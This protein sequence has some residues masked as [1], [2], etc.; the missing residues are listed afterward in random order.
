MHR[1]LIAPLAGALV[2]G[3]VAA[4]G[5]PASATTTCSTVI[6]GQQIV[7]SIDVPNGATCDLELDSVNGSVVV[8]PGGTLIFNGTTVSG[9]ITGTSVSGFRTA[10]TGNN[11]RGDNVVGGSVTFTNT[12]GIIP[13]GISDTICRTQIGGSL[14]ITRSQSAAP[15]LIGGSITPPT[16]NG[17]CTPSTQHPQ[18]GDVIGGNVTIANNAAHIDFGSNSVHG[19]GTFNGNTNGGS[20]ENDSFGGALSCSGNNPAFIASGNQASTNSCGG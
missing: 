19:A 12:Q 13:N 1:L 9:N 18:G 10:P 11:P 16:T 3:A 4:I 17:F 6:T 7:G 14:T 5:G 8:E 20:I 15:T 2:L